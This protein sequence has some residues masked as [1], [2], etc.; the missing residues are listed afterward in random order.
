VVH[1]EATLVSAA[2]L[3]PTA[4]IGLAGLLVMLFLGNE[5]SEG[6]AAIGIVFSTIL[7]IA[8]GYVDRPTQWVSFKADIRPIAF[9]LDIFGALKWAH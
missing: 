7:A 6:G 8:L 1:N 3:G 4:L 9:H 5:E 2:P